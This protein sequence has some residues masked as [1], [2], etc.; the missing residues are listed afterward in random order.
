MT[1]TAHLVTGMTCEH[2]VKAVTSE[3][4]SISGISAVTVD[5]VPGGGSRVTVTSETR[6]SDD[7]ITAALDEAGGYRI[8]NSG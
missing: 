4:G 8:N 5:L 1:A 2:Y 3:L 7:A 6:L